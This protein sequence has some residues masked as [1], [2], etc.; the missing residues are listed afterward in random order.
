M[1]EEKATAADDETDTAMNGC[2]YE[3]YVRLSRAAENFA[4]LPRTLSAPKY[5]AEP[6][7]RKWPQNGG[8]GKFLKYES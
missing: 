6:T 3:V 8:R 4:H 5:S 2:L 7:L 1:E